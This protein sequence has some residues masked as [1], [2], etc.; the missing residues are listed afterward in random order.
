MAK[1]HMKLEFFLQKICSLFLDC[2]DD[3][4]G[5]SI[6]KKLLKLFLMYKLYVDKGYTTYIMVVMDKQVNYQINKELG[7]L[8]ETVFDELLAEIKEKINSTGKVLF[9][10]YPIITQEGKGRGNKGRMVDYLI[11]ILHEDKGRTIII[12]MFLECRN[13]GK[14]PIKRKVFKR[15]F[16]EKISGIKKK[17]KSFE[18][19]KPIIIFG[20]HYHLTGKQKKEL[21]NEGLAWHVTGTKQLK[22]NSSQDQIEEY[23]IN[24]RC[25]LLE[26]LDITMPILLTNL[27]TNHRV[28]IVGKYEIELEDEKGFILPI[29]LKDFEPF[30]KHYVGPKLCDFFIWRESPEGN[31]QLWH[32]WMNFDFIYKDRI[33]IVNAYSMGERNFVSLQWKEK[34]V[35]EFVTRKT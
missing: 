8:M 15:K 14:Y 3:A 22:L 23:K 24:L 2:S 9:D 1:K 33:E 34:E 13:W 7:N 25:D 6:C 31:T 11:L 20:G 4:G 28:R 12:P 21:A 32:P 18:T 26:F 19:F 16:L 5:A 17:Y 30:K 27:I 35:I 29:N 10:Y